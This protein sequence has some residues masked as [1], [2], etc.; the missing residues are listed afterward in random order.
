MKK[1]THKM[2][3]LYVL[4]KKHLED[5]EAY[6]APSIVDVGD[7]HIPE[8]NAYVFTTWK[9]PA[10][11]TD[12]FQEQPDLFER[13]DVKSEKSGTHYYK[14]RLN[15]NFVPRLITDRSL[16]EFFEKVSGQGYKPLPTKVEVLCPHG[17]P[18]FV[19]CPYCKKL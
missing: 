14:Y 3:C 15:L 7:I 6:W 18:S 19:V 5:R 11:L 1:I 9:T 4:W 17:V 12:L 13:I 2:V 8:L 16:K 10:R